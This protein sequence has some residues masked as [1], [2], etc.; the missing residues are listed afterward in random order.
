MSDSRW[1]LHSCF[2]LFFSKL[3]K[4]KRK[5]CTKPCL[6]KLH[7]VF[8]PFNFKRAILSVWK[9][10]LASHAKDNLFIALYLIWYAFVLS[11]QSTV[12]FYKANVNLLWPLKW[13]ARW[14]KFLKGKFKYLNSKY[15]NSRIFTLNS[16]G[17]IQIFEAEKLKFTIIHSDF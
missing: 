10:N 15:W 12:E 14:L 2:N 8:F 5:P 7:K 6:N 13:K 3:Q 1:F 17:K 11:I 16:G 4:K 9:R